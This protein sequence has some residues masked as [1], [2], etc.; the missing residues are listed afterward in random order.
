MGI[1]AKLVVVAMTS[2]AFTIAV[3]DDVGMMDVVG[4]DANTPSA[5]SEFVGN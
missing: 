3:P 2:T 5:I 4:F 1:Q